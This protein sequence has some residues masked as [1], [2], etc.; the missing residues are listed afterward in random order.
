MTQQ[1]QGAQ[2]KKKDPKEQE[3]QVDI[4]K[5][6]KQ[7]TNSIEDVYRMFGGDEKTLEAKPTL[8]IL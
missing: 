5:L 7:I 1:A 2:A 3:D 8:D 6:S 4:E